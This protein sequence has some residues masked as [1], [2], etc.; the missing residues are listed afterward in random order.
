VSAALA[1]PAR[2]PLTLAPCGARASQ[3]RVAHMRA[4]AAGGAQASL[5]HAGPPTSVRRSP[6]LPQRAARLSPAP[7]THYP[8]TAAMPRRRR[9]RATTTTFT[10][11]AC[12]WRSRAAA[13]RAAPAAAGPSAARRAGAAA[14]ASSCAACRR[15]RAGRT[16]RW[17]APA[18]PALPAAW[19][20]ACA[21][22]RMR[23]HDRL[24]AP[25]QPQP[26]RPWP[27]TLPP[28][29]SA[30]GPLPHGDQAQLC[31]RRARPRRDDR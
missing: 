13:T 23:A 5:P 27:L 10:A 9:G 22:C 16:S 7:C 28:P 17:G 15:P 14:T 6:S 11:P 29:P 30:P 20:C 2:C 18:R 24:L 1:S 26:K 4:A 8:S 21:W 12:V 25:P 19:R 3:Q 31:G